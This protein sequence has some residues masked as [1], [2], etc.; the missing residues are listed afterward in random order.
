MQMR[1]PSS[2]WSEFEAFSPGV[3][4][5]IVTIFPDVYENGPYEWF[6]AREGVIMQAVGI[7]N[8]DTPK[9]TY[10]IGAGRTLIDIGKPDAE[11]L[12]RSET[13]TEHFDQIDG[14]AGYF[15]VLLKQL[16]KEALAS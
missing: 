7:M 15:E 13:T 9:E 11:L 8:P 16:G 4:E 2:G 5:L 14:I 10:K 3:Q 6:R 12:M 1:Q